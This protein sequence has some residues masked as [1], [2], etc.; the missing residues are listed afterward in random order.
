MNYE[1]SDECRVKVEWQETAPKISLSS[2]ISDSVV[3][4]IHSTIHLGKLANKVFVSAISFC[5]RTEYNLL[6][7][8][9]YFNQECKP[10]IFG[11]HC[12]RREKMGFTCQQE[13]KN[14]CL[15]MVE[16]MTKDPLVAYGIFTESHFNS[17]IQNMQE[18]HLDTLEHPI[19]IL[20]GWL[21]YS[22][23]RYF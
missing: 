9:S 7:S 19:R 5:L 8:A 6:L 14:T 17:P 23:R 15:S 13:T 11:S 18:S 4:N 3:F 2:L 1:P 10:V 16:S 21:G 22:A 20:P 12:Y